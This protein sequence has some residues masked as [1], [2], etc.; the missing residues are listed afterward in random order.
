MPIAL[1]DRVN[2]AGKRDDGD[3]MGRLAR[4]TQHFSRGFSSP[5]RYIQGPGEIMSLPYYVDIFGRRVFIL[6]DPFLWNEFA[7][8]ETLFAPGSSIVKE[9]FSGEVSEASVQSA[10]EKT[11][12]CDVIVG[13]G[14]GKAIDAAKYAAH[15]RKMPLIVVPTIA[16]TDAPCSALSVVSVGPGQREVKKCRKNPDIVL[17]DT[18]MI[19]DAPVRYLVAGMGD[20]MATFYEAQANQESGGKNFV[21]D[22][23][24]STQLA[25]CAARLCY[26]VL[27]RD[28]LKAR[29]AVEAKNTT[30]ALENVI[31]AN[32][33]LSGLGFENTGCAGAHSVSAGLSRIPD[34]AGC[35][36]GEK[37]AFGLL[38]QLVA[39][40]KP[41]AEIER[42]MAFYRKVGAALNAGRPGRQNS[43]SKGRKADCSRVDGRVLGCGDPSMLKQRTYVG[44][45]L[46]PTRWAHVIKRR[47]SD[48]NFMTGG[49][50]V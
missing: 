27:L 28:G 50:H 36:H 40:N 10:A 46:R 37:V 26:E 32:I 49:R 18:Q 22:G 45:F 39:E 42:L 47:K 9:R 38:C 29:Q 23:F 7:D 20:A 25:L 8:I 44:L 41:R 17:V 13:I 30:E 15:Q 2:A 19:A 16:S 43:A 33:L 24:G 31:E 6:I 11:I 3:G 35:L 1:T 48:E 12:G 14:G 21:L 34:C 5:G 4:S